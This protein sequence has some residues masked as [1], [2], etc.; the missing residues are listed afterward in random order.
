MQM[1]G[2]GKEDIMGNLMNDRNKMEDLYS[3]YQGFQTPAA[4]ILVGEAGVDLLRGLH[5][6]VDHL[7]VTLS[8]ESANSVSFSIINAY[9]YKNRAFNSSV[10]DQLCLGNLLKLKLGYGSSLEE[11]FTGFIYSVK[12]EFGE[13]AVL[14]V[15]ALD[16]RR[17]MDDSVRKGVIWRYTTYSAVFRQVMEPYKKLY[18]KLIIDDTPNNEVNSLTQN[19]SDHAFAKRLAIEG[20]REFFVCN[21]V[22][23]FRRKSKR[24]AAV[25]LSW[26]RDLISFSKESIYADQ[27]VTVLGLMKDGKEQVAAT[28]EVKTDKNMKQVVT[29]DS[30]QTISSPTSDSKSKAEQK[31]LQKAE[32]IRR[33]KQSGQGIC[34]GLPQLVPGRPVAITGLDSRLDGGY[35]MKRVTHSL[36]S[37]GFQTSFEIGGFD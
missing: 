27:K 11:V 32:E 36:G 10:M 1:S 28:A 34:P 22:V 12:A 17:V 6:Q 8:L 30:S 9:D 35:A 26:G 4:K 31:A 3:K 19:E 23:Y 14:S 24:D 2:S 13:M 7:N 29:G 21:D 5:A 33:K 15:V 16:V 18:A 25:S 37:D 20:N